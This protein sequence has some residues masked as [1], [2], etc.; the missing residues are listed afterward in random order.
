[1]PL[2]RSLSL[3]HTYTRTLSISLPLSRSLSTLP[4]T[5]PAFCYLPPPQTK[6]IVCSQCHHFNHTDCYKIKTKDRK[7]MESSFIC[8]SC[9]R[10]N[11]LDAK[12]LAS[13]EER[14]KKQT[15]GK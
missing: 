6:W 12:D 3:T 7:K 8:D 11:E 1:M 13:V 10:D 9:V 15:T 5:L 14:R 2:P 4:R